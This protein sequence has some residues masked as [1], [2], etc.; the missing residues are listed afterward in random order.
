[1]KS[2]LSAII[3]VLFISGCAT[4]P[5]ANDQLTAYYGPQPSDPER[6]VRRYMGHILKDPMS[7]TYQLQ[8]MPRTMWARPNL[9]V[10]P[11]IYGWGV[12]VIINAK[13][14]FGGY[15]GEKMYFFLIQD[16]KVIH[17]QDASFTKLCN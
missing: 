15:V 5:S 16:E 8:G 13:N 10:G 9:V 17:Y 7:A 14:S 12:C 2:L 1:M 3:G 4:T 11:F 6:T